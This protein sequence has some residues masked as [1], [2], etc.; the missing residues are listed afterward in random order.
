M[1]NVVVVVVV[2][3]ITLT[4][5]APNIFTNRKQKKHCTRLPIR[6]VVCW[7]GKQIEEII[8][9]II[10]VTAKIA[11]NLKPKNFCRKKKQLP[12]ADGRN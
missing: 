8:I 9:I 4:D 10:I 3:F 11:K 2:V 6:F 5:R 12:T 7:T 1:G